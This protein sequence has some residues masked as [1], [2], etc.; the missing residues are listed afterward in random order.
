M[1]TCEH[2]MLYQSS[3]KMFMICVWA[4]LGKQ[5]GVPSQPPLMGDTCTHNTCLGHLQLQI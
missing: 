5:N 2:E 4:R 1:T 3:H